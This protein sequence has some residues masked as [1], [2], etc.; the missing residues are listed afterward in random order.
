MNHNEPTIIKVRRGQSAEWCPRCKLMVMPVGL[1]A[2]GVSEAAIRWGCPNCY[3]L[4]E[5]RPAE[6]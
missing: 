3:T 6:Q 2:G 1:G 5:E 4:T